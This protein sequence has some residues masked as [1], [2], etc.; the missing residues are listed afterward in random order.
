MLLMK[1]RNFIVFIAPVMFLV[2]C[3][4]APNASDIKNAIS[5]KMEQAV[6]NK[7]DNP[8]FARVLKRR[9]G[10]SSPED[11]SVKI[12]NFE[13]HNLHQINNGNWRLNATF[14]AVFGGKGK[15]SSMQLTLARLNDKW[16]IV[17]MNE[18]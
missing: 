18:R 16:K 14:T 13:S 15:T 5:S 8:F 12:V 7:L 1:I 11:V 4:G 3:S 9:L 10:V 6:I 17:G 2:A